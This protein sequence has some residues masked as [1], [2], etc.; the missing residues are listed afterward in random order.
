LS[1]RSRKGLAEQAMRLE[2]MVAGGHL[3][4]PDQS[5]FGRI[6]QMEGRPMW[7]GASL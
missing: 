5:A 1:A 2:A 4:A 6:I 7:R 3:G